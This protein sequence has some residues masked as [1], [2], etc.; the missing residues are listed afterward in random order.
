M[1]IFLVLVLLGLA[2]AGL[3]GWGVDSRD[4]CYRL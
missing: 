1:V 3:R 2:A 4:T